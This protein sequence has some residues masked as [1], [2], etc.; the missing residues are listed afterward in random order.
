M[1]LTPFLLHRSRSRKSLG[2]MAFAPN[3]NQY[4]CSKV[5]HNM[6]SGIRRITLSALALVKQAAA[7]IPPRPLGGS[8]PLFLVMTSILGSLL[9]SFSSY[10]FVGLN[11][12]VCQSFVLGIGMCVQQPRNPC[13]SNIDHDSQVSAPLYDMTGQSL[14]TAA[15]YPSIPAALHKQRLQLQSMP[16]YRIVHTTKTSWLASPKRSLLLRRRHMS[17]YC[18]YCS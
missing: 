11:R 9:F 3:A 1:R 18:S 15:R 7:A 13:V 8:L 6:P 14:G 16:I 4:P 2:A 17:P 12:R 10:S 5:R